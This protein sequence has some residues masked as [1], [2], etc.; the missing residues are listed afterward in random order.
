[1][2]IEDS[3]K[4]LTVQ[5]PQLHLGNS[6]HD[7]SAATNKS[8]AHALVQVAAAEPFPSTWNNACRDPILQLG[9]ALEATYLTDF[10]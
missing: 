3:D 1:M 5:K 6:S 4:D 10:K 2:E 8:H 9:R 7:A